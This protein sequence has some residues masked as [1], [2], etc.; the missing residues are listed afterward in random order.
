MFLFF[1][2]P[3][4]GCTIWGLC[5]DRWPRIWMLRFKR[6]IPV[7]LFTRSCYVV[8]P[9]FAVVFGE[10]RAWGESL[11]LN[12]ESKLVWAEEPRFYGYCRWFLGS[13]ALLTN[14]KQ[15]NVNLPNLSHSAAEW[16]VTQSGGLGH[17]WVHIA[18]LGKHKVPGAEKP[19][20]E[21]AD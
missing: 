18:R 2:L 17:I 14:L 10:M 7:V 13:H 9:R 1:A 3:P 12:Q 8:E 21:L 19:R 11:L 15:S 4:C 20:R 16:R 5:L 6:C